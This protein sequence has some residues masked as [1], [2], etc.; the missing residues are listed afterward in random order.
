MPHLQKQR[1][2]RLRQ[3]QREGLK[4]A[5]K[6]LDTRHLFRLETIVN[7]ENSIEVFLEQ[8]ALLDR[9][10]ASEH[11]YVLEAHDGG[12][13]AL[14]GSMELV[15]VVDDANDN[16]PVFDREKYEIRVKE[17]MKI[18]TSVIKVR[19]CVKRVRSGIE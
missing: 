7:I 13:P 6:A 3:Q 12:S 19:R 5:L 4:Q 15:V 8:T 18:N 11:W 14:V 16:K 9:E 2:L 17:N 1:Q 10:A